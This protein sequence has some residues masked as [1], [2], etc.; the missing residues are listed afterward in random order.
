MCSFVLFES[1]FITTHKD[2]RS[3]EVDFMK[4]VHFLFFNFSLDLISNE[5][6]IKLLFYTVYCPLTSTDEK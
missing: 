1:N 5:C 6:E 2:A 4:W 3:R